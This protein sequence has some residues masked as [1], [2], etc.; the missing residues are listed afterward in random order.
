M[1]Q[2]EYQKYE[3][4]QMPISDIMWWGKATQQIFAAEVKYPQYN[5]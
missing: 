4:R 5:F 3:T 2:I 1:W